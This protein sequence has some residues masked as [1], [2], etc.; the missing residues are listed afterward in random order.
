MSNFDDLVVELKSDYCDYAAIVSSIKAELQK[1]KLDGNGQEL[2]LL[3]AKLTI[4]EI[5]AQYVDVYKKLSD[6][7]FYEAWCA[8][9]RVEI[10]CINLKRNFQ[11][12]F[13]FVEPLYTSIIYIQRLYPY[14]LFSS[15]VINIKSEVCSICGSVRSIRKDCGHRKGYVYKGELCCNEVVDFEFKGI[16]L[17]ENPVHKFAVLFLCD[18]NGDKIDHYNYCLLEGLMEHWDKPFQSWSYSVE[19]IFKTV[20]DFPGLNDNSYC[21]CGSGKKFVDCCKNNPLGIKHK[22]YSFR[23]APDE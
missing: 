13:H 8:A 18:K 1:S 23:V 10:D 22:L 20:T 6:S 21:P 12:L 19:D 9:E 3:W 15:Y 16:D 4:T 2:N 17:V 5:Y 11:D 7:L 14:N